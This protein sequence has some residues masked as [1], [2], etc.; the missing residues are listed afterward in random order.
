MFVP[1]TYIV[2]TQ[3]IHFLKAGSKTYK[4][5]NLSLLLQEDLAAYL[6]FQYMDESKRQLK[7][8]PP[9]LAQYAWDQVKAKADAI[10]PGRKEH[11]EMFFTPLGIIYGFH[12]ACQKYHAD[13]D[14]DKA[15]AILE[16]AGDE[17]NT[18]VARCVGYST[19]RTSVVSNKPIPIDD[20]IHTLTNP[21][22]G[23]TPTQVRALSLDEIALIW[24]KKDTSNGF[25]FSQSDQ[26]RWIKEAMEKRAKG[27]VGM[28][29]KESIW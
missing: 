9:A 19:E 17:G 13:V 1:H 4:L 18:V 28:W 26:E 10:Y 23:Y 25:G 24:K 20:I 16:G 12:L 7:D 6:R 22:Y 8:L 2:E 14:T 3:P 5:A 29:G 27:L 21:P 11:A 15:A